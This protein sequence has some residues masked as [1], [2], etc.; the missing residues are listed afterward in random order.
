MANAE[1]REI[2]QDVA[3]EV[4]ELET[5][6]TEAAAIDAGEDTY[7][8]ACRAMAAL[9]TAMQHERELRMYMQ[10]VRDRIAA[11]AAADMLREAGVCAG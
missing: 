6:V 9:N 1:I 11:I 7:E 3:E 5:I 2:M 4:K 8:Q 10:G